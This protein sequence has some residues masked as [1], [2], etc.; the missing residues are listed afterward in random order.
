MLVVVLEPEKSEFFTPV[1]RE[2]D[3]PPWGK[4]GPA[5]AGPAGPVPTGLKCVHFSVPLIMGT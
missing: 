3:E 5:K 4:S 2:S 1:L